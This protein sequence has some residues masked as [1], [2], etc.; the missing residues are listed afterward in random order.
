MKQVPNKQKRSEWGIKQLKINWRV[1][2][3][4]IVFM[5]IAVLLMAIFKTLLPGLIIWLSLIVLIVV[6][7]PTTT[8]DCLVNPECQCRACKYNRNE[9]LEG[10]NIMKKVFNATKFDEYLAELGLH[11]TIPDFPKWIW[12]CNGLTRSEI[13][14]KGYTFELADM[15]FT[16]VPETGHEKLKALCFKNICITSTVIQYNHTGAERTVIQFRLSEQTVI[17]HPS[18]CT[19]TLSA[20][21]LDAINTRV[22]ELGW[23][24]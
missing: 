10:V 16:E 22:K 9:H 19:T 3:V 1:T 8:V 14:D 21:L 20:E 5:T 15:F 2:L 11:L 24:K 13:I 7:C 6:W 18:S 12:E 17:I 4:L 23:V